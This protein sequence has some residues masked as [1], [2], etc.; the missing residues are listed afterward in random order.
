MSREIGDREV[1]ALALGNL[2][3]AYHALG[4]SRLAIGYYKQQ[5]AIALA[6]GRRRLEV[7]GLANWARALEDL[8]ERDQAMEK[9]KAALAICEETEDP[10]A[11]MVRGL[12]ERLQWR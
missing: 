3:T 11:A 5:I 10:R 2:G 4:E 6:S 1:E 12:V 7:L 9:A 8:G